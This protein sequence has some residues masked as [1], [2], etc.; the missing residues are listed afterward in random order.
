[1]PLS[2]FDLLVRFYQSQ[3][4][5]ENSVIFN[6]KEQIKQ[7]AVCIKSSAD[8]YCQIVQESCA[9]AKMTAQCALYMVRLKFSGLPD[10]THGYY[11][12]HF[13]CAFVL[14][15]LMNVPSKFEIRSF[16]RSWNNRGYPKNLCSPWIRPRSLF[17]KIINGLLFRL[18]L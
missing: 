14:I 17:S 4:A 5:V 18:A 7:V 9:I 16:T 2:K 10:Y 12:Q 15:H 1:M 11:F 3:W 8:K 6:N 13:S